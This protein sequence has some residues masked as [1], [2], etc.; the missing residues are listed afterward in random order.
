MAAVRRS[1]M[2]KVALRHGRPCGADASDVVSVDQLG[3]REDQTTNVC[4]E[5]T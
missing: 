4:D 2:V 5:Q 3:K 1:G